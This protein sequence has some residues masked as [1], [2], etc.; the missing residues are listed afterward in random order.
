MLS[1]TAATWKSEA[2]G[3]DDNTVILAPFGDKTMAELRQRLMTQVFEAVKEER[4]HEVFEV[5]DRISLFPVNWKG[6]QLLVCP[7]KTQS[8]VMVYL[9]S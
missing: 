2:L 1:F 8:E 3:S 6:I 4:S 9:I 7:Q 5:M